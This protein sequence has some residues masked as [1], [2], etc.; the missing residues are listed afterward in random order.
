MIPLLCS[1]GST[2]S[3]TVGCWMPPLLM[4]LLCIQQRLDPRLIATRCSVLTAQWLAL[5]PL[6]NPAPRSPQ[7]GRLLSRTLCS[8]FWVRQLSLK[9]LAP[10]TPS[11]SR[12]LFSL[13]FRTLS[14]RLAIPGRTQ[15]PPFFALWCV[16]PATALQILCFSC[17]RTMTTVSGSCQAA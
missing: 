17:F 9:L 2:S 4:L 10:P 8:R 14:T 3:F 15:L 12:L 13:L 1:R 5:L 16:I 6:S 11:L 7:T